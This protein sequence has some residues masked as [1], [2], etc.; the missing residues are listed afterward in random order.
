MLIP[1]R[2]SQF[3]RD[4]R[5]RGKDM[6]KSRALLASLASLIE[7]ESL[8]AQYRDHPLRGIWRG[9]REVHLEPDWLPSQ[10]RRAAPGPHWDPLRSFR[11]V[12]HHAYAGEITRYRADAD[13]PAA[14]A[15]GSASPANSTAGRS[16][17]RRNGPGTVRNRRRSVGSFPCPRGFLHDSRRPLPDVVVA[18][19]RVAVRQV[20][21]PTP[22][23]RPDAD[24]LHV[25]PDPI[26]G[27]RRDTS[28]RHSS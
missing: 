15:S 16:S 7:Q 2:S 11:G 1:V 20:H 25:G 23:H 28:R 4:V 3:K 5:A 27:D 26:T 24:L 9:D 18:L 21:D 12:D 17:T 8:A 6:R 14:A 13:P 22:A 10:I 19:D